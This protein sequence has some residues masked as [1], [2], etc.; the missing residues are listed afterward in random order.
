MDKLKEE[1]KQLLTLVILW[2]FFPFGTSLFSK[3][4]N[5]VPHKNSI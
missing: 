1:E 4:V 5:R 2:L 3:N